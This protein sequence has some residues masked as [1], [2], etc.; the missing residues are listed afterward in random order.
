MKILLGDF[1]VKIGRYFKL[2]IGNE[3]VHKSS[4]LC[5]IKEPVVK[6]RPVMFPYHKIHK[7]T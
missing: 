7:Y 2:I 1:N 3:T 6:R 5:H 4:K